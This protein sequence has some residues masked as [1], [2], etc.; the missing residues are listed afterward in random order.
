MQAETRSSNLPLT[1]GIMRPNSPMRVLLLAVVVRA[2]LL[3]AAVPAP[4]LD[5]VRATPRGVLVNLRFV[6]RR[7][8]RQVLRVVGDS[9]ESVSLDL[10]DGVRK[11][12]VAKPGVMTKCLAVGRNVH[13]LRVAS[14]MAEAGH[15]LPGLWYVAIGALAVEVVRRLGGAMTGYAVCG[16]GQHVVGFGAF[17]GA[18]VVAK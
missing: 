6:R 15:I 9:S 14:L 7:A 17:E 18:G 16:S 8:Q 4:A 2:C 10:A 5:A 3:A 12:H 11:R 1:R 13:Q